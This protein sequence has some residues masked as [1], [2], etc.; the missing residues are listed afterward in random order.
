MLS[1]V[2]QIFSKDEE[3]LKAAGGQGFFQI[4]GFTWS[5]VAL[6][7]SLFGAYELPV[8]QKAFQGLAESAAE[9]AA[10]GCP[11]YEAPGWITLVIQSLW[12]IFMSFCIYKAVAGGYMKFVWFPKSKDDKPK[13]N[14]AAVMS[15]PPGPTR[16]TTFGSPAPMMMQP[17]GFPGMPGLPV[18]GMRFGTDDI[19]PA[20]CC[21]MGEMAG[22][23]S[24][25]VTGQSMGQPDLGNLAAQAS[26][27]KDFIGD[28]EGKSKGW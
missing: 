13:T 28:I 14:K 5:D 26:K 2:Q 1:R 11:D 20:D 27:F 3:A 12:M 22:G 6:E 17:A 23:Q 21:E 16:I 24:F 15:S 9:A 10:S 19:T 8:F 25:T 4:F 18:Y 7:D